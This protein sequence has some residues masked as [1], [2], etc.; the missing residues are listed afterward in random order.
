MV[1]MVSWKGCVVRIWHIHDNP[2]PGFQF[3][4]S[5]AFGVFSLRSAAHPVFSSVIVL[6]ASAEEQVLL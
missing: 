4:V 1:A 3:K 6:H 5:K 2:G